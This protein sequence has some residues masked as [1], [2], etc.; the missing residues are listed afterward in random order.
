MGEF[1]ALSEASAQGLCFLNSFIELGKAGR[2]F[3]LGACIS[4]HGKER[5]VSHPSF[6]IPLFF[7]LKK[8][9]QIDAYEVLVEANL[10]SR[11]VYKPLLTAL[12]IPRALDKTTMSLDSR[13]ALQLTLA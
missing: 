4:Y 10:P 11:W 7:S 3:R 8:Y 12:P 5:D 1:D 9:I 2:H 6:V 13:P